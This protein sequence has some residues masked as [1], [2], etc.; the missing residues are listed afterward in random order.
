MACLG[1]LSVHFFLSVHLSVNQVI[2]PLIDFVSSFVDGWI[3]VCLSD[4]FICLWRVDCRYGLRVDCLLFGFLFP[5]SSFSLEPK[6]RFFSWN[7]PRF[8]MSFF[9][10]FAIVFS[11]VYCKCS[12]HQVQIIWFICTSVK[13]IVL[14]SFK[15]YRRVICSAK[16]H[17]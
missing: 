14:I 8:L 16:K 11:S 2:Y 1:A 13:H 15:C 3:A 7:F 6:T 17:R 4:L 12:C 9:V 10:L 5:A